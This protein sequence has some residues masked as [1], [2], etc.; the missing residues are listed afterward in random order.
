MFVYIELRLSYTFLIVKTIEER[1][2]SHHL[3]R[4]IAYF[5]T[6]G[7]L[8]LTRLIA[9]HKCLLLVSVAAEGTNAV[10]IIGLN[11]RQQS[12]LFARC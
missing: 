9:D 5:A 10:S 4:L 1:A 12:V 6:E 8:L 2:L 11:G 7:P 3:Q